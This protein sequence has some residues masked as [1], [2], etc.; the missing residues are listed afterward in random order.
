MHYEN[1]EYHISCPPEKF[2]T[3][4]RL[5][6][7]HCYPE[8]REVKEVELSVGFFRGKEIWLVGYNVD[9]GYFAEYLRWEK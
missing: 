8:M 2:Q 5:I 1:K 4:T 7:L 6:C 9:L 3:A